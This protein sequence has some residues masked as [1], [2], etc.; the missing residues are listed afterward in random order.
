MIKFRYLICTATRTE[1]ARALTG[2]GEHGHIVTVVKRKSGAHG[3][4]KIGMKTQSH[5]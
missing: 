2:L 4:V 3:S 5:S 1:V